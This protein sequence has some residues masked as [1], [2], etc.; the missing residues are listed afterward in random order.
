MAA[1][2]QLRG[3]RS[4]RELGGGREA[5]F[6]GAGKQQPWQR[7]SPEPDGSSRVAAGTS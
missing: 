1:T 3:V 2:E 7:P 6:S 5:L 4:V